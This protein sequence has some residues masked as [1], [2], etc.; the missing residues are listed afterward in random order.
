[1]RARRVDEYLQNFDTYSM[2]YLDRLMQTSTTISGETSDG[3][4]NNIWI[5]TRKYN[6]QTGQLDENYTYYNC[7]LS[8]TELADLY[9]TEYSGNFLIGG[10]HS[11]TV[12]YAYLETRCSA[13]FK[14]NL[15]KYRRLLE[16]E[17]LIWNPLWNVDG[18]ELHQIIEQHADE[19]TKDTG[20]G[21]SFKGQHSQDKRE[22]TP[23]DNT[24][25]KTEYQETH[26]GMD[27][28]KTPAASSTIGNV[29]VS[30]ST[31]TAVP[32][33][34]ESEAS[35]S[36]S[37]N[38]KSHESFTYAVPIKDT[39]FGVALAGGDTL[40]TEKTVRKGNIGV[41][42]TTELI[43]DARRVVTYSII[44]EFF[45]DINEV[46]LVGLWD[47]PDDIPWYEQSPITP[48][49]AGTRTVNYARTRELTF[50]PDGN[51]V[52]VTFTDGSVQTTYTAEEIAE[53]REHYGTDIVPLHETLMYP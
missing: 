44:Q 31:T 51:L 48:R 28:S 47:I 2:R 13:I 8:S 19:V 52:N 20:S 15:G 1:M 37:V 40:H 5:P 29:T 3:F 18:T 41:T 16:L 42:K 32:S 39:A 23:Y 49:Q 22:V 50:D 27:G 12:D 24:T 38:V 45:N 7:G 17:G 30:S 6:S 25:L 43:E 36:S 21:E 53:E 14:K 34:S 26:T 33:V 46:I 9:W 11:I 10:S 35:A 4:F